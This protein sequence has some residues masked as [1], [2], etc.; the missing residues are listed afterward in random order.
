VSTTLPLSTPAIPPANDPAYK[1]N[2]ADSLINGILAAQQG[3]VRGQ[4]T[5]HILGAENRT[6][7][8]IRASRCAFDIRQLGIETDAGTCTANLKINSTSVTGMNAVSV[9]STR[10]TID[11]TTSKAV[12]QGDDVN[13][14]ITSISGATDLIVTLWGDMTA[15]GAS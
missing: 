5:Y 10:Q 12:A 9:T 8:L 14:T 15:V 11:G 13:L 4:A 2:Y 6:Y 1:D 7:T 3:V